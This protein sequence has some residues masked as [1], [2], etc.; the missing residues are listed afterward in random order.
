MIVS[1]A[2]LSQYTR[3]ATDMQ[4]DRQ[5]IRR[6]VTTHSDVILWYNSI[7]IANGGPPAIVPFR[8]VTCCVITEALKLAN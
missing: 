4:R 2:V 7:L 6:F 3:V 5:H 1:S 8:G